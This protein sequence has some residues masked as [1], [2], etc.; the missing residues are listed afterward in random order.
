MQLLDWYGNVAAG[1]DFYTCTVLIDGAHWSFA[2]C[3]VLLLTPLGSAGASDNA[4]L[5]S[6]LVIL[7]GE[8]AALN[9]QILLRVTVA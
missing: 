6:A 1:A 9:G 2:A 3:L 4:S 5:A 7:H 8:A